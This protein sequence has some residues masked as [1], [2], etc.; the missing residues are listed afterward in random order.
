M[1]I[2][3]IGNI[4]LI[5]GLI[6]SLL[7]SDYSLTLLGQK[8]YRASIKKHIDS[9]LYELN[10]AWQKSVQ[11]QKYD[12]RHLILVLILLFIVVYSYYY[13]ESEIFYEFIVG[14]VIILNV[15]VLTK[16]LQNIALFRIIQKYPNLIKGKIETTMR[17]NY[18]TSMLFYI[19]IL[20]FLLF[21]LL[22]TQ[23]IFIL[24]G[25]FGV[26]L[27]VFRHYSWYQKS[28]DDKST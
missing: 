2:D 9:G 3:L 18:Y 12:Y 26:L 19:T 11:E 4:Y 7:I 23:T 25:T 8:Y 13:D 17:L 14:F 10:P 15:S 20:L 28:L 24:G 16:H 27:H 1:V 5:I 22:F 6:L 21:V